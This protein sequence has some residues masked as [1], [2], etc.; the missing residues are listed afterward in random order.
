M[1]IRIILFFLLLTV[2]HFARAQ[3]ISINPGQPDGTTYCSQ[4]VFVAPGFTM[5]ATSSV[6]GMKISITQ[7]Y[8]S[9][10]DELHLSGGYTGPVQGSWSSAYGYLVLTGG[11]NIDDYITAI[12]QVQYIN[13]SAS[14]TIGLR[15]LTFSLEDADYLPET[16]HFYTFVSHPGLSWSSARDEAAATKY[17][18]L[19]GY[20]A[21]ITSSVE[22][23]F[24]QS[25]TKGVGWIG[26]SDQAAEGDWRWVTGPEGLLDSGKGLLFWRGS[27]YQAK[28][29]PANYG[30]VN[31]AYHNWNRWSN[32]LPANPVPTNWEPNDC[33]DANK[34][35]QEDYAHITVFP[36]NP[37]ESYKWN[38]LPNS[39]GNGPYA[40]QG[41]L[42]EFGGMDYDPVVRLTADIS[43]K[44]YSIGF[45]ASRSFT[46]CQ[47]DSVRL[48]RPDTYASYVWRS[49]AGLP[50]YRISNPYAKPDVTTV[51]SVTA[52]NGACKDSAQFTVNINPAP[53]SL[54]HQ[55]ENI[56]TGDSVTLDPGVH[57]AY[58]W[59]T[60]Q[61]TEKI[62]VSSSAYYRVTLTGTNGCQTIDS[63]NVVVHPYP[64]MDLSKLDTL[65]CGPLS[66]TLNISSSIGTYVMTNLTNNQQF[67]GTTVTVPDYG[68]FP[69]SAKVTEYGCSSDTSMTLLF[70][71]IP[72]VDL[73]IDST[74]CYGYNLQARYVGLSNIS[75]SRFTWIFGGDTISSKIGQN[76]EQIPLGVDQ[77]KR[78]LVLKVTEDG[79]TGSNSRSDI[80]VIPD[81]K[82][83]VKDSLQCQPV[84]FEFW[85]TNTEN[86]VKYDWDWGDGSKGSGKNTTHLYG[87]EGFYDVNLLV[88]TDKGCTNSVTMNKMVYVAPIPT[89]GFS[90][91]PE[92][93]LNPGKDTLNY[94]GSASNKDTYYW[95]LKGFDPAGIIQS[96]DTTSGPFVFDL[97]SKPK[98]TLSLYVIS[99]Y[100]CRSTTSSLEV[101]RK[102][103]FSFTS[104]T[105]DGCAPVSVNFKAKPDDPVDQLSFQWDYGDG[106]KGSG[107]EVAHSYMVP[108]QEHD[109][110]LSALSSV[111]GCKD[112]LLEPKYIVVHP[113]P[114][115]GFTMDHDIVYNDMPKVSFLDQ[116][117]QSVNYYWNFGDGTHSRE[118]DPVH[119]YAVVGKRK[120][121]QTV[122]NQ[123]D[124]Q[125]T[126]SKV[127]LVAFS[128]IFAP[129]AFSPDAPAEIDREFKLSSEGIKTE[130]Y[131]LTI[132][133]R[134]NDIV[135]ECKNEVRGWDGKMGNGNY[136]PAGNYIWI[137]EC[138]DFLGRRHRQTG[139][140][141]LI[142]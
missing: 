98:T 54:L 50:N 41:Y 42:I 117:D 108:N 38:D 48:N 128:R 81:L 51:Y 72:V 13:I 30:P 96:P 107:A 89:V 35:H 101:K 17:H 103:I 94:V 33:C 32:P 124:C 21:T 7:G 63:V 99:Q 114:K 88:T 55:E 116:S 59:S 49:D 113:N 97:I 79:C 22:N 138:T 106:D 52:T 129:N 75:A 66:T 28:S 133:S 95:D 62:T 82:L 83:F 86:V 87:K 2:A 47:G 67:T 78:D 5:V 24:I 132:L 131:H 14:P 126:T 39:G 110:L 18:G 44:V 36:N 73:T 115:A 125:D 45:D 112:S 139:S 91:A 60:G 92:T 120:V 140:L 141:T 122:Y 121:L 4:P 85:A 26:A 100:G 43:L 29:D 70:H 142:F 102:P 37:S 23:D 135:F 1:K 19:Q 130:G 123:F 90:I 40:S 65:I 134:W 12:Q 68:N 111:T 20:L 104:S 31:G 10:E 136:A 109:V 27:G 76:I 25:K 71:K 57:A 84:P 58:L 6:T 61:Q 105:R 64:R 69:F 11:T 3:D 34:P 46:K 53:V 127:V 119:S 16:Q 137:L 93:C 118:K 8:R 9:G 80:L 74:I 77:T 56:C 15:T